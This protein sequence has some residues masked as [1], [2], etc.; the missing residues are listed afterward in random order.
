MSQPCGR[1]VRPAYFLNELISYRGI[2]P[3]YFFGNHNYRGID[4]DS[5]ESVL[6]YFELRDIRSRESVNYRATQQWHHVYAKLIDSLHPLSRRRKPESIS[7]RI[8]DKR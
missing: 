4:A 2:D 3:A 7:S 5:F 1:S 8:H 6:Q